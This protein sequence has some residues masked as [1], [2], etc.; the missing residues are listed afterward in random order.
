MLVNNR[1]YKKLYVDRNEWEMSWLITDGVYITNFNE[2]YICSDEMVIRG[3][4][5]SFQVNIK[6]KDMTFV[7]VGGE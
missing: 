5:E 4:Y 3:K 2:I 1:P 7:E 6:Y